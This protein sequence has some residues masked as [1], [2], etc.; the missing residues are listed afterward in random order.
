MHKIRVAVVGVGNCASA[1][2]QGLH[3]Y[4]DRDERDVAGLMHP[5]IGSWRCTDLEVVAAFDIDGRKV[6]RPVEEAIFAKPNCAVKFQKVLPV[7]ETLV[8]MGPVLDG[9]A[10][11]MEDY[12]EDEAFRPAD[13]KPV[14]VAEVLS[15]TG[16]EILIC[17]LPVGS[18]QAV[19][20]YAQACLDAGVAMVNCVPVFIASDAAWADKFAPAACPLWVTISR[21]RSGPPSSTGR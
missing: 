9:F 11:H 21:A 18:E 13:A 19:R 5:L 15:E 1:L 14:D 17:Y 6:G 20:H 16:A 8:Q 2:I 4:K 10:P 7:S 12:P 3:F